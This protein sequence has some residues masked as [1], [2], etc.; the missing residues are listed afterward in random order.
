MSGV[1]NYRIDD[2]LLKEFFNRGQDEN[3]LAVLDTIASGSYGECTCAEIV[4]KLEKISHN[5][6]S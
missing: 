5:N 3:N 1:Q 4:K 6:K 2:E